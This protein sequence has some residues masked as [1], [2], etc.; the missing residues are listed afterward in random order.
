[1]DV[2]LCLGD[3]GWQRHLGLGHAAAQPPCWS[4]LDLFEH[5]FRL[6]PNDSLRMMLAQD[7]R[8]VNI[9]LTGGTM[10]SEKWSVPALA[11]RDVFQER[12]RG[13]ASLAY[14]LDGRQLRG[15][16]RHFFRSRLSAASHFCRHFQRHP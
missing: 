11:L 2:A 8:P 6:W 9:S 7:R 15:G 13:G 3:A 5:A 12:V 16:E 1:M 10:L 4:R 14:L